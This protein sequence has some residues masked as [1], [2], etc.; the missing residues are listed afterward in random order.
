M[1]ALYHCLLKKQRCLTE[2]SCK[3][4]L[5]YSAKQSYPD[6]LN[7]MPIHNGNIMSCYVDVVK[8]CHIQLVCTQL[9]HTLQLKLKSKTFARQHAG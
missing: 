4:Y 3:T 8:L 5:H 1:R 9:R 2:S 6:T 7:H